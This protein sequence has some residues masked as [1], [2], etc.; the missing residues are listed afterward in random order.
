MRFLAL[1]L[2]IASCTPATAPAYPELSEVSRSVARIEGVACSFNIVGTAVFVDANQAITNAHVMAGVT[3]PSIRLP[4]GKVI[5][6]E[7]VGFDPE[8]DLALLVVEPSDLTDAGF[9][10]RPARLTEAEEGDTGMIAPLDADGNIYLLPYEVRREIIAT[11]ADIYREG[12]T[13]RA[14]LDLAANIEPGDSGAGLFDGKG[15]L[16]G[17]AFASSRGQD[18]V[19]YAIAAS[20][21]TAFLQE[22]DMTTPADPGP[23]IE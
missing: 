22:T 11:G 1:A 14:A 17:I 16:V 21:V 20:E 9:I 18:L 7:L 3:N 12:D 10:V 6:A 2:V 15:D 23:C 19:T 4:G 8:R 13:F 5:E